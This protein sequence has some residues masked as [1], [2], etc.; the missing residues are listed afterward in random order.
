MYFGQIPAA[1]KT[2]SGTT[3]ARTLVAALISQSGVPGRGSPGLWVQHLGAAFP[4]QEL[5]LSST[6]LQRGSEKLPKLLPQAP[7]TAVGFS[8]ST[9]SD[10]LPA[11]APQWPLLA[12]QGIFRCSQADTHNRLGHKSCPQSLFLNCLKN[13]RCPLQAEQHGG[14]SKHLLSSTGLKAAT[15]APCQE[16]K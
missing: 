9:D 10:L 8:K 5:G 14:K 3:R 15:A 4:K 16:E 11:L 13:S 1:Q 6:A 7:H 2:S 12:S